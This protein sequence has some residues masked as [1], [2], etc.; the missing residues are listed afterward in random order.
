VADG[1]GREKREEAEFRAAKGPLTKASHLFPEVLGERG[2]I[3]TE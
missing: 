1:S 3:Y 2:G